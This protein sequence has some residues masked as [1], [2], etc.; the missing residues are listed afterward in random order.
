[1]SISQ[2]SSSHSEPHSQVSAEELR[3]ALLR[4]EKEEKE[5]GSTNTERRVMSRRARTGS[6]VVSMEGRKS[7]EVQRRVS[8]RLLL[9][10][11]KV[12]RHTDMRIDL[13]ST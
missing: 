6:G 5:P 3:C 4:E 7:V 12:T 1:M 10:L 9:S 11:V 8:N 13:R 2:L